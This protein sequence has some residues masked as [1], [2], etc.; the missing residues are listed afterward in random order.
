MTYRTVV[1]NAALVNYDGL[2]GYDRIADEVVIYDETPEELVL[3][4]VAG[5]DVVVTK[6]MRVSGEIIRQFPDSVKMI[7]EAGTGYNNLDLEA[8]REKGIA[9]CNIPAYSSERVAHT[10]ILLILSLA[11]SLQKQIRMLADGNHDNFHR[12]LMVDHVEV[13][14]KTLGVIGYGN[15][16]RQM[17]TVAQALG[18]QVIVATRTPREDADGVHFTTQEEVF[19]RS[20]FLSLNCPLNEQTRHLVNAHTLALMKPSAYVINTARGPLIDEQA[21]IEAIRDGVVAGAGLDVQENEPLD[22]SSPLYSMD[23]VI[24]TPHMGW[25]GLETRQRLVR[26]VGDNIRAFAAGSPINRV[27]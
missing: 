21:L 24:I 15:I 26:M 4:R 5:F 8:A 22:D 3:E 2:A 19:R 1:L 11:S 18:M 16:A 6:E 20:D 23:T 27:A 17:I 13:N 9:V 25:R 7:C 10:A 12:H 14:G